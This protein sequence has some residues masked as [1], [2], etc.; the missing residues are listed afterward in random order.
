MLSDE[1]NKPIRVVIEI[2]RENKFGTKLIPTVRSERP[3]DVVV[4][5]QDN[6][7]LEYSTDYEPMVFGGG[8]LPIEPLAVV[9]EDG[10]EVAVEFE[11]KEQQ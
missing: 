4:I 9:G 3:A 11:A 2:E 5:I 10:G 6:L 8:D 1:L 7:F